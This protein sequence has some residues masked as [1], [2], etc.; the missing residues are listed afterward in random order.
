[1]GIGSKT[2]V[3]ILEGL[4]ATGAVAAAALAP[5]QA[6]AAANPLINEATQ[7]LE[8][9][10]SIGQ[11]APV[12]PEEPF[13][14]EMAALEL[15]A[16]GLN[17]AGKAINTVVTGVGQ[18]I[19]EAGL[20]VGRAL[21]MEPSTEFGVRQATSA[22]FG[23]PEEQ[24]AR[25]HIDPAQ[26]AAVTGQGKQDWLRDSTVA[27][28]LQGPPLVPG[29]AAGLPKAEAEEVALGVQKHGPMLPVYM[30]PGLGEGVM[31]AVTGGFLSEAVLHDGDPALG[32]AAGAVLGG[33]LVGGVKLGAKAVESAA[34]VPRLLRE[35][36]QETKSWMRAGKPPELNFGQ[37]VGFTPG[38]QVP[39]LARQLA[40]APT[41]G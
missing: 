21:G 34:A 8:G 26:Q 6:E 19:M 9:G 14:P 17:A 23:S 2:E 29:R 32:A 22:L 11:P 16:R 13:M 28:L 38:E 35:M 25:T 33:A 15:G 31:E 12:V 41:S 37:P 3:E 10:Q 18:P 40:D 30:M 4:L 36:R 20:G 5:Q 1:M 27:T 24:M 7:R 39:Q